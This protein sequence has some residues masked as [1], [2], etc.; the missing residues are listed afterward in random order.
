MIDPAFFNFLKGGL[1]NGS[2]FSLIAIGFSLVYGVGG[3]LNLSHGAYFLLTGYIALLFMP[4]FIGA[5]LYSIIIALIIITI[6]GALSY[7]LF[8]KP[9]DETP[10][11]VLLITFALGYFIQQV[12]TVYFGLP[13]KLLV[14]LG[15]DGKLF[16]GANIFIS[17]QR[18]LLII[19]SFLVL[20]IFALIIKKTKF[21]N[22]IRAVSQDKEA[23][24]LMGINSKM[25]LMSTVLIAAFLAGL[26]AMLYLPTD[27]IE[28]D[29]GFSVLTTALTCVILGGM[30]SLTG[31]VLGAYI[32]SF[33]SSFTVNY[34]PG[35][36][37]WTEFIPL[38][39]IIIILLIRPRGLFGKKE[40]G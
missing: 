40:I 25:I 4:L 9:M 18:I 28:P 39:L 8:I 2:Y 17:Y 13:A 26:A 10:T 36:A 20:I 6:L 34:V 3:I 21:G 11:G 27:T 5:Q 14:S 30:G 23:A 24:S 7:L 31:S 19:S 37:G 12:I 22:S 1:V 32:I 35:G 33:A 15:L 38:I 16:L 29:D